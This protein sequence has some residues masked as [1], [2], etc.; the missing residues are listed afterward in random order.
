MK[1]LMINGSPHPSGCT[2]TALSEVQKE[3]HAAGVSTKLLQLGTG[4]MRGCIGCWKC[5]GR[6]IFDGDLVNE[7]LAEMETAGALIVGSPVYYA[8]A[9]GSLISFLDRFFLAGNSFAHKPAA[10][11][12]SARRAGTTATV[13]QIYQYFGLDHMPIVTSQYWPMVHGNTPEEVRQDLEGLQTMRALGRNMAWMLQC[14]EAGK[15]N[16]ITPPESEHRM[17]TNFIR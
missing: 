8:S 7:A 17:N 3:L 9:N 10:C 11:V 2:Y 14:I 13:E 1:V 5:E 6:C 12:V 4:A 15:R 16:G